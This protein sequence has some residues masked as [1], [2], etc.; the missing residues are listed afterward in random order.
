MIVVPEQRSMAHL[1][2]GVWGRVTLDQVLRKNAANAPDRLALADFADR[3]DWTRGEPERLTYAALDRRVEA[4]AAFFSGLGLKPDTVV[5]CQ[6]PALADSVAV[7]FGLLRAGLIAAP[8]PLALREAEIT[9]RLD[10]LGAKGIVTVAETVGEPHGERM[11]AVAADLFQIRFVFGAGGPVP[12][13][14]IPLYRLYEEMDRLPPMRDIAR[15]G[16]AADHCATVAWSLDLPAE[17]GAT[18]AVVPRSHNHWIA[19][20]LMTLLEAQI[21]TGAVIVSSLAP[22]GL[23]GLGAAVLPWLLSAGTLVL[24]LPASVDR[25]AEEVAEHAAD[26]VVVPALFARRLSERLDAHKASANLLVVSGD[27]LAEVELPRGTAAVDVITLG[28]RALIA[29]RRRDPA[30][31]AL[32]P[33]GAIGAPS[34]TAIAPTL[35]ETQLRVTPARPGAPS[36]SRDGTGELMVRGAMVPE[37]TWPEADRTGLRDRPREGDGWV[38]TGIIARPDP[39]RSRNLILTGRGGEIGGTGGLEFDLTVLDALFRDVG[40]FADAAAVPLRDEDGFER[41]AAAVVP[42][43]GAA[44]DPEGFIAALAE[45]RIG[46]HRLPHV[47]L[48]VPAIARAPSGRVMRAGMASHLMRR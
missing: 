27:R 20:G 24:G 40:D 42:K 7:L 43:P 9:E 32:I 22:S 35:V 30:A 18:P 28:E 23:A 2:T 47:V 21:G 3:S 41:L 6:L 14:L 31:A 45:H 37:A 12:D 39:E 15:K 29:R 36:P 46:P 17:A 34:E 16:N 33:L 8:L 25:L 38:R 48:P 44:F 19:T 13:G 10:A 1:A 26:H 4:L 5:A 11:L